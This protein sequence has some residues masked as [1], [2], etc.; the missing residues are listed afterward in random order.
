[1]AILWEAINQLV[2][3]TVAGLNAHAFTKERQFL[4]LAV[5]MAYFFWWFQRLL[6][7]SQ[8]EYFGWHMVDIE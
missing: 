8:K 1:M 6:V 7:G 2:A 4:R 3:A 5:H